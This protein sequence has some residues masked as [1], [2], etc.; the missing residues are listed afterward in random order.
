MATKKSEKPTQ[1]AKKRTRK[2]VD[3]SRP[4]HDET[5]TTR[6]AGPAAPSSSSRQPAATAP[7]TN[8][9]RTASFGAGK[10]A[11]ACTGLASATFFSSPCRCKAG[12]KHILIDCGV[13]AEDLH[14]IS[15]RCRT[16]GA[17]NRKELALADHDASPRRSHL[18]LR[19]CKDVFRQFKV[20]RIW[21]SWF[22]DPTDKNAQSLQRGSP[23]WRASFD[24]RLPHAKTPRRNSISQHGGEHH[25]R[26]DGRC[27]RQKFKTRFKCCTVSRETR[28]SATIK[29]ATTRRCRKASS[30]PGLGATLG[31]PIDE[32][33]I[34]KTDNKSQEYLAAND[35][36]E[37][38]AVP[39]FPKAFR[40]R[41]GEYA[42]AAF[43][44]M[45]RKMMEKLIAS[46]QPDTVA[47]MAEAGEQHHQQSEPRRS[48][49]LQR[50]DT[51]LRG[52]RAM[53]QLGRILFRRQ[54]GTALKPDSQAILGKLAFY[55]VGHHGSTNATP[56]NALAAMRSGCVAMCSTAGRVQ[57]RAQAD[58]DHQDQGQD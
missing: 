26:G 46:V 32:N 40:I 49:Y 56:K 21:M 36:A 51:A 2:D 53:G 58:A 1:T 10:S 55:K 37:S 34:K 12:A 17:G 48:L 31:P 14:S 7:R 25:R 27:G 4:S 44:N 42:S 47:G 52:R 57:P 8:S 9:P 5:A 50:Q 22:E 29:P 30:T 19:H 43:A 15:R 54:D 13:H 45:P 18:R 28:Q 24:I 11:C 6:K 41:P 38:S 39:P 35:T 33:L 23:R 16:N 3:V 20:E